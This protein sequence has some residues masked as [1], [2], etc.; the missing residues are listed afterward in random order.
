MHSSST[1]FTLAAGNERPSAFRKPAA[2]ILKNKKNEEEPKDEPEKENDEPEEENG[3]E[4][5]DPEEEEEESKR[6]KKLTKKRPWKITKRRDMGWI[7][8]KK[9]YWLDS[10]KERIWA[11]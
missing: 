8:P 5:E 9:R 3:L 1:R 11:G 4:E 10:P 6:S 7:A 2:S